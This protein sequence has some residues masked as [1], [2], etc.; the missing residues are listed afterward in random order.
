MLQLFFGLTNDLISCRARR[1]YATNRR[2]IEVLRGFAAL[3]SIVIRREVADGLVENLLQ[4]V[5]IRSR[6][7]LKRLGFDRVTYY[8]PFQ[9]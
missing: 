3:T 6:S 8:E 7:F 4:C 9:A 1:Y 2:S 5:F